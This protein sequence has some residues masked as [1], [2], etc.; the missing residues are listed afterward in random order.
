MAQTMKDLQELDRLNQI[1][2]A[3]Y[4]RGFARHIEREAERYE[5]G[6]RRC[7]S[8]DVAAVLRDIKRDLLIN[9]GA[10]DEEDV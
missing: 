7:T 2:I 8:K 6:N 9:S 10:E 5:K 1:A 4:A 3:E